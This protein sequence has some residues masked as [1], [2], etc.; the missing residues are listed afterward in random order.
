MSEPT[1]MELRVAESMREFVK[2][3]LAN[4]K[5]LEPV[6]VGSLGDAWVPIARAAI[7]AISEPTKEML[8]AGNYAISSNMYTD[9]YESSGYYCVL[10]PHAANE[11]WKAMIDAASPPSEGGK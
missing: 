3:P 7:R 2:Q 8:L 5:S 1:E 4:I 9:G 10:E 11:A 6:L